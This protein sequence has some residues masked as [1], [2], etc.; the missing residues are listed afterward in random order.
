MVTVTIFGAKK[1]P[2]GSTAGFRVAEYRLEGGRVA[3]E[4]RVGAEHLAQ[5]RHDVGRGR[6]L[7]EDARHVLLGGAIERHAILL[8]HAEQVRERTRKIR[9]A[10]QVSCVGRASRAP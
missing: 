4:L 8:L 3:R 2:G 9:L 6:V 7:D 1:K 5:A 10:S